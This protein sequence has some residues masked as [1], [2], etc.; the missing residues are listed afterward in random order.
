MVSGKQGV[1]PRFGPSK[2]IVELAQHKTSKTVWETTPCDKVSWGNQELIWPISTAALKATPTARIQY[3]AQ[4]KR[5]FS[6]RED[7]WRKREEEDEEEEANVFRK[8]RHPSSKTSQYENTLRLSAPRTRSRGPQ[9][10][11]SLH[12]PLCENNC[13]IWHVDPRVR[14]VIITARLLQLSQPK[15]THPDYRS[16]R[17]S[18]ASIVSLASRTARISQRLAQ[19]SL[20]KLKQSNICYQLGRFEEPIWIVSRA[21]KKASASVRVETLA[22]PKQLHQDYIPPQEPE[23][24]LREAKTNKPLWKY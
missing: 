6:A 17:E 24:S 16:N 14:N 12:T 13:P 7:P 2:R 22:A 18:A 3:L 15:Q 21:A 10:P 4:H 5:D 9:E 19:L 11:G 1:L 8:T 20:P 23:W